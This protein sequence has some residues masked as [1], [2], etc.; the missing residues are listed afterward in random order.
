M[1][2]LRATLRKPTHEDLPV[3]GSIA[4]HPKK[5]IVLINRV[6]IH[7]KKSAKKGGRIAKNVRLEL[8][9]KTGRKAVSGNNFRALPGG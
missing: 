5:S 3:N 1:R 7:I 6:F 8:E 4:N 2:Y 9:Q